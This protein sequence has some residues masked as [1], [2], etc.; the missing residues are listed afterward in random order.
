MTMQVRYLLILTFAASLALMLLPAATSS[1]E[2]AA[3]E[4]AAAQAASEV[5][6]EILSSDQH[7]A[8]AA[9]LRTEIR[10]ILNRSEFKFAGQGESRPVPRWVQWLRRAWDNMWNR[11]SETG[12]R[13]GENAPWL[14]FVLLAIAAAVMLILIWRVLSESFF[15]RRGAAAGRRDRDELTP[16]MLYEQAAA[17][18]ARGDFPEAVR[19]LF[20]AAVLS[21]FGQAATTT[22]A[23]MLRTKLMAME[24][25][26]VVEFTGLKRYFDSSFYGG[27]MVNRSDYENAR[28]YALALRRVNEEELDEK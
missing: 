22:P 18:G 7:T 11:I 25:A 4:T 21:L 9:Q 10:A 23:V 16:A 24:G 14:M 1:Q 28:N 12:Q 15:E 26:P 13:V 19:L 3:T 2:P 27:T 20:K 17:A 8:R 5:E 6:A